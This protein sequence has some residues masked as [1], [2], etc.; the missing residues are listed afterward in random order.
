MRNTTIGRSG[1]KGST[2]S[3][4]NRR[5][6]AVKRAAS[7]A[8]ERLEDRRLLTAVVAPADPVI[9]GDTIPGPLAPRPG[10][11]IY[12]SGQTSGG[13]PVSQWA[14]ASAITPNITNDLVL[15]ISPF[16][17]N[18][19]ACCEGTGDLANLLTN[20]ITQT[21]ISPGSGNSP[22][23]GD[24]GAS[25]PSNNANII[26]DVAGPYFMSYNLAP[27]SN[28]YDLSEFDVITGHQDGRVAITSIDVLVEPVGSTHFISLSGGQGFSLT[29][30]QATALN[31][32][33]AQMAI[34]NSVPG[35][36]SRRT[37]KPCSCRFLILRHFS[38]SL[39]LPEPPAPPSRP[40]PAHRPV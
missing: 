16:S 4:S 11:S 8:A 38:A 9:F 36:R 10:H 1:L 22:A 12:A 39:L 40:M 32:G 33:S 5:R 29:N 30:A 37:F 20:G 34:V 31:T 13:T 17:T 14:S 19:V 6:S 28:G 35:S 26:S 27:N 25:D 21:Q 2:A 23:N 3:S 15:N 18:Y 7:A 24:G